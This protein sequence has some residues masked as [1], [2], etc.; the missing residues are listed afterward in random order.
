M[1]LVHRAIRMDR[2]ELAF[3]ARAEARKVTLRVAAAIR[4]PRWAN[5]PRRV[6]ADDWQNVQLSRHFRTRARRFPLCPSDRATIRQAILADHPGAVHAASEQGDRILRGRVSVLGYQDVLVGD[7]IDWHRDPVHDRI[8]PRVFWSSVRYL[9]P[10]VGDHKVTWEINRHQ[11]WLVLGR[12]AWLT[13]R[14][15]YT[16]EIVRQLRSWLAHNPPLIGINWASMLELAFRSLSWLWAIPFVLA[17]EDEDDTWLGHLLVGLHAQLEHVRQNLSRYFS[18]NTHLLGEALALYVAGRALPEMRRA[19]HWEDTGRAVLLAEA[20][21]QIHPDGGHVELSTHYHRYALDFYLLALAIARLTSDIE[22]A[23]C[24]EDACTRLARY[25]KEMT[26][27]SG[28]MPVLGDDDGGQLFPICQRPPADVR[29]TLAWA[30]ELLG[31]SSLAV[32]GGPVPEEVTW[33]LG[34]S[35]AAARGVLGGAS[36]PRTGSGPSLG[37]AA[38]VFEDSGYAV[39]RAQGGRHLVLDAG[40]HGFLNGGH[41]H[42]DLLGAVLTLAGRPLA[43]DPGTSTYTMDPELR[44]R[45]RAARS[46]N[47]VLVDGREPAVPAGPFHW[48]RTTDGALLT[49]ASG[50]PFAWLAGEHG[51]YAPLRVRRGLFFSDDGLVV[52]IDSVLP[53]PVSGESHAIQTRWHLDPRWICQPAPHGARLMWES[54]SNAAPASKAP[55]EVRVVS[56]AAI[57]PVRGGH[58]AG[59]CAPVYGQLLPT[60]TL[61]ASRTARLPCEI[62]TVFCEGSLPPT[63]V[64]T[65][66]GDED[67]RCV[68]VEVSRGRMVDSVV[69]RGHRDVSH[70][71]RVARAV[72]AGAR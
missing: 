39:A 63:L 45:L 64:V 7:P 46:H 5:D 57:E 29:P 6:L 18:P 43:I 40:R 1:G 4:P 38:R 47:T 17:F 35:P 54:I 26:P 33:L 20:R 10:T 62:V 59:W 13:G 2:R 52:C 30:A 11:H 58:D 16:D 34:R 25:A 56:N 12:A 42:A 55:L 53:G 66:G 71:R 9:D 72:H 68:T 37:V 31:D 8:A 21:R 44:D 32:S 70:T 48:Q 36:S 22:A 14:R 24:F 51:G 50:G 27:D 19:P 67:D 28:C 3:R 41:A 49:A 23:R 69:V 60:W 61:I 65:A 15:V